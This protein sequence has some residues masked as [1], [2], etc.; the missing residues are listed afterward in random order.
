MH[1]C[2]WQARESGSTRDN[3][4]TLRLGVVQDNLVTSR[5]PGLRGRVPEVRR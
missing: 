4:G 3:L 1:G 5:A 2:Y